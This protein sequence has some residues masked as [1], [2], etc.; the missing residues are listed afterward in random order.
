MKVAHLTTH[1]CIKLDNGN[2][3]PALKSSKSSRGI[4]FFYFARTKD[5]VRKD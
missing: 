4:C 3:Y 1:I 2:F 5:D